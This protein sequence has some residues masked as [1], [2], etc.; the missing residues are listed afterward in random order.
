MPRDARTRE[1]S[2][3]EVVKDVNASRTCSWCAR[4]SAKPLPPMVLEHRRTG[5]DQTVFAC[6]T[7]VG[8]NSALWLM[9]RRPSLV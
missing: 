5:M 4:A 2:G 3:G 8:P 7:C 1:V 6:A 9:F